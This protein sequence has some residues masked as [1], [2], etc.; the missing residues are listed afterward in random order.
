MVRLAF[1]PVPGL[2]RI[3]FSMHSVWKT[4]YLRKDCTQVFCSLQDEEDSVDVSAN[5]VTPLEPLEE[6]DTPTFHHAVG[7]S[8]SSPTFDSSFTGKL[9]IFFPKFFLSFTL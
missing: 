7:N 1:R 3:A 8:D 5:T 6:E 4:R 2:P 9:R